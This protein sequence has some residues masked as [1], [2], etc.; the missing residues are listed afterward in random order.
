MKLRILFLLAGLLI[1]SQ[2]KGQTSL[3]LY[4]N[5]YN[6]FH[7]GVELA[8]HH[9]LISAS[10]KWKSGKVRK[11]NLGLA[12]S[13]S[14]YHLWNNHTGLL[15]GSD[16]V[17]KTISN[18]GYEFNTFVGGHFLRVALANETYSAN[19]QGSFEEVSFPGRNKF[20][21]R[22]GIGIGKQWIEKRHPFSINVRAGITQP[23]LP[24]SPIVPNLWFGGH[25]FFNATK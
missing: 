20:H 13:I 14:A 24:G 19:S 4:Y 1:S 9:D 2:S 6:Y 16:L 12:P 18:G 10:K 22:F 3:A 5:A 25:Y 21:W 17:V 8:L 23:N 15:A 7:P 11:F